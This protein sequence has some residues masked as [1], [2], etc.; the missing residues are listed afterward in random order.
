MSSV[1]Y[2][3]TSSQG[4]P[5][6]TLSAADV[7]RYSRH[8]LLPE[9]G[10]EGQGRLKAASVLC[11]GVGGLG[12]SAALYLAAA[13]IGRLGLVDDD[14]VDETNLQR[15][16]LH[17]ARDVGRSKIESATDRLRALDSRL[18]ITGHATRLTAANA[19]DLVDG[20]DVVLDGS[21]NFATRYLVND[22]CV[23]LGK[24]NV[25]GSV[26][27]FEGQASV[28]GA[29]RGPCYRC[30]H[31]E[32]P[33]AGLVPDCAE[34]GVLGVLPGIIGTIQA[35]E[36]IKLIVGTGEPLVGRLLLFDALSMRFRE[37]RLAKDPSCPVCGEHPTIRSLAGYDSACQP[38]G[39]AAARS[40]SRED[41]P[42]ETTVDQLKARLDAG[43]DMV[44]LDVREPHEAR[45]CTIEGSTI[46]PLGEV[47]RRFRE[48]DPAKDVVVYCR[49]GVRSLR[50]VMFLRQNGYA[51][52]VNLAGGILQ[53]IDRVDPSQPKY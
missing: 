2:G 30:L 46:M 18:E 38:R 51:R 45:I 25:Y 13:G 5:Q 9:V 21:D 41:D 52:A 50:A 39:A 40:E 7:L 24:A 26:F 48:L 10:L 8:L 36:A 22:A 20:Y 27:R 47:P 19:R 42:V 17:G 35:A 29:R 16:V 31:P 44:L 1:P 12:S 23:L 11:V 6:R 43:E 34:A 32:P 15:Q 37:I 49:S 14:V 28:F 53:W 3:S 4:T 33:A